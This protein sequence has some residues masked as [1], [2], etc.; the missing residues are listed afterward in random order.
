MRFEGDAMSDSA[1]G[2]ELELA[3]RIAK[4]AGE[5]ILAGYRRAKTIKKKGAIDL[6]TEFDLASETHI[7]ARLAEHFVGDEVVAEEGDAHRAHERQRG[8]TWYV[9]PLDGTT[10]YAHGHAFFCVAIALWDGDEGQLGVVH[11]PALGV[12]WAAA[13]GLGAT[14][15]GEP[16]H[17]SGTRDLSD[18]LCATGF[19]YDRWTRHGDD[20]LAEHEA[21][22]RCTQ[23]VRRCGSAAID[24]ASVA[25]GTYEIYWEKDLSAWDMCAGAVLVTEAGGQLSSLMGAPADPRSGELLATNGVLHAA[26]FD[27]LRGARD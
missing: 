9:D 21:F 12:T 15:N 25:D 23:G 1:L 8:R 5:L 17:V 3:V 26:A 27:V 18:A 22:L 4:E 10:N 24:L 11:A 20:N 2:A 6:V 13:R 16:C 7:R 14:R 19:P